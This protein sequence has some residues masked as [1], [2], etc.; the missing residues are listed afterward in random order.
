MVLGK[1]DVVTDSLIINH[2]KNWREGDSCR[3]S[4]ILKYN[5]IIVITLVNIS[6]IIV[7]PE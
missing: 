3:R 7:R 6:W 1:G 4:F 2:K 5:A